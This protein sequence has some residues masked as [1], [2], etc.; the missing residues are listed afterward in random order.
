MTKARRGARHAG[1]ERARAP[2]GRRRRRC[3]PGSTV[4]STRGS[5]PQSEPEREPIQTCGS[6]GEAGGDAVGRVGVEVE[7]RDPAAE[8]LGAQRRDRDGDVVHRAE[9]ARH[10][11]RGVV[12]AA[13]QVQRGRAGAERLARAA[14]RAAAGEPDGGH[15][16]VDRHVGRVD[17]EDRARASPGG[18]ATRAAPACARGRGSRRRSGGA[19]AARS[20]ATAPD[21]RGA[22]RRRSRRGA[23]RGPTAASSP[24]SGS[25]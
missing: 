5:G 14:E 3:P 19:C 13:E 11:G 4:S 1:E 9:A 20:R 21:S 16:L 8:P 2:R 6:R 24:E 17:A 22:T 12:E 10:A 18:R 23:A 25:R 15:H 7:H